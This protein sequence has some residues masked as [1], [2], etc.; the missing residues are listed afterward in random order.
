MPHS[1]GDTPGDPKTLQTSLPPTVARRRL[2]ILEGT[3]VVLAREHRVAHATLG[4][5]ECGALQQNMPAVT[6]RKRHRDGTVRHL[7]LKC[8]LSLGDI[9]VLSG[10][11]R[12][13]HRAYPGKFAT[14]LETPFSE[15]WEHNPHVTADLL[16]GET[17]DCGKVSVDRNG[18]RR[19]HY[20]Q[21]YL[22]LLNEKLGTNAPLSA[23]KGDIHLSWQERNWYSDVWSL[24]GKQ[25]P[26]WIICPGGKFDIPIKWWDWQRYQEV[27]NHFRGRIQFVQVGAW[28]NYHPKLEGAI[29]LR[30]RTRPRDLIHLVYNSDGVF[31]GVTSLMHL[32]AAVPLPGNGQRE[33]VII[34]GAREPSCWEAYPGHQFITTEKEVPCAHCWKTRHFPLPDNRNRIAL[35]CGQVSNELPLCMDRIT[36]ARVIERFEHLAANGRIRF[37]SRRFFSFGE[38]ACGA[39]AA[40]NTYDHENIH[41]F[42]AR[43]KAEEFIARIRGYPPKRF[44]GRGIV[45]CS[46]GVTYFTG[47]WVTI[48]MLRQLGCHL[49]IELWHLGRDELDRAMEELLKP[50]GVH[51]VNARQVMNRHSMRNPLGW[52]LKSYAILHSQ[53]REVL[54]LDCDNVPTRN[55]EFLFNSPEYRDAGAVFWPDYRRLSRKRPI[56][57]ICGVEYRDEPEVESGQMLI[58]KEACWKALNLAF[59]YN[60]HSEFFYQYIHGDKETFHLAWR[61]TGTPYAM[62]ATPIKTLPGTMCQHDFEGNVL[63]QH[64]N[65]KKWQ[66][67]GGNERVP[68]FQFEEDCL[69]FI[70]QLRGKWDGRIRGRL[71]ILERGGFQF[72]KDCN[73]LAIF[74]VV[75]L[76]N[77]YDL[78]ERMDGA[79]VID[80]GMHIGS[81][82]VAAAQR[83]AARIL[84]YEPNRANFALAWQNLRRFKAARPCHGA[85]LHRAAWIQ[86]EVLSNADPGNT[87]ALGVRESAS[88]EIPAFALDD[89]LRRELNVDLLKL[90]CEGSEWPI[91]LHSRELHRVKKICGEYH[92]CASHPLCPD[93][94]GPL[95][96]KLLKRLL[97]SHFSQVRILP[98][99]STPGLGRFWASRPMG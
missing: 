26:Y 4:N 16:G 23:L 43:Q 51:C 80:V 55:P 82:S 69:R 56:W 14:A 53:F 67:F 13:L 39:A 28:G 12:D 27:V 61:K 20:L 90:D 18:T 72:R 76:Y 65:L 87:G 2:V 47:A 81:F 52:E 48:N 37:L 1:A 8:G 92:E 89:L 98:N 21:A 93:A 63:F 35:A 38:K 85:V 94:E 75:V 70:D 71:Q 15:I 29:D 64:R 59:W 99:K 73:D 58:N 17:I 57:K 79:T 6:A 86:S 10:A 88:A 22:D 60:D 46:G 36:S 96:R 74:A 42:N 34:G 66:F 91:L 5:A 11:V 62:P 31:C 44:Q 45:L 83:G 97:Q 30:G 78:P 41:L 49:P 3:D 7:R 19:V 50:I 9:V 77:E 24:C 95:D 33:A 84:G 68:G 25:V 32:A 40:L 54:L